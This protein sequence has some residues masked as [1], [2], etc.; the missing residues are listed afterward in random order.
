MNKLRIAICEDRAEDTALLREQ[1]KKAQG[2]CRIAEFSTGEDFLVRFQPGAYH[3]VFLDVYLGG[4]TGMEVAAAIRERDGEVPIAFTTT[5]PDHA[6][7][8]SHYRS[9]LYIQK[10]V[11]PDDVSHCLELAAA[12]RERR[13]REA[14]TVSTS[15][16]GPREIPYADIVCIEVRDHRCLIRTAGGEEVKTVTSVTIDTLESK[17]P[18]P[19]FLRCHRCFIVNLLC[20][21]NF[22]GADF[23]MRGGH[24]AYVRIRDERKMKRIYDEYIFAR[25]RG[26]LP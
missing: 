22:D 8:A 4:V 14:L 7:E 2:D 11:Q 20:V 13:Q 5:S 25:T 15:G 1:V 12:L 24:R 17:L 6:L 18:K 19:Q 26:E 23:I 10:P 16:N 9:L 3:M 21:E